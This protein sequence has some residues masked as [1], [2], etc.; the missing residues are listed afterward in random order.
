MVLLLQTSN[1]IDDDEE[2]DNEDDHNDLLACPRAGVG[3]FGVTSIIL[4][5]AMPSADEPT[6]SYCVSQ[7]ECCRLM[8]L[9]CTIIHSHKNTESKIYT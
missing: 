6:A 3:C 5:S 2:E 7:I 8:A 9:I 1:T 4:T